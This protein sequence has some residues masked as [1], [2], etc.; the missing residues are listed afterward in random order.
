MSRPN[1]FSLPAQQH[2]S[3]SFS[4]LHPLF[5]QQEGSEVVGFLHRLVRPTRQLV[6]F[7]ALSPGGDSFATP[8][9]C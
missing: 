1:P 9:F 6:L 2:S 5:S 8:D 4:Y 3:F 7:H